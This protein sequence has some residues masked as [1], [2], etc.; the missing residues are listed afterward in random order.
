MPKN[1]VKHIAG[2]HEI[3]SEWMNKL[4]DNIMHIVGGLEVLN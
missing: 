2:T 1:S 3:V 4:F